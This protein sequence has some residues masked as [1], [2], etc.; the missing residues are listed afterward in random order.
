VICTVATG[1][2][3]G[4]WD[5]FVHSRDDATGYHLWS[6][7]TIFRGALGHRCHYLIAA[8]G[9]EVVGVLPLVEIRSLLFGRALSSLPYVNYGGVLAADAESARLLFETAAGLA[10]DR[11]LSY[12]LLRHRQGQFPQQP[13]RT[14]KVTMLLPL[15][16]SRDAMWDALD[17]K[18]RNQIRK[19]E[20]SNLLFSSGGIELVDEFYAV[21]ARNMRDLGTPVYGRRLFE[22]ILTQ[23]PDQAKLH[24]VRLDGQ[25]VAGALSY[26]YRDWI[27]VPSASSLREHRALCPNHLLYWSIISQAITDGRRV[28][29]FG[30]STP[31]DG[32]YHFKEQWR[33]RAEELRW[34]YWLKDGVELPSDDRHSAKFSAVIGAWKRLPVPLAT[35]VGPAIARFVP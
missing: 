25:V 6:W 30:R 35:L 7:Q 26:G 16:S 34:E 21:F 5:D 9:E 14:H 13:S 8:R 11:G 24:L 33:A 10:R 3:A 22:A 23:F 19:A 28:F 17:R 15:E 18:V 32:T 31:G 1:E 29:D 27:E 4:R 2:D 12:V 20:K